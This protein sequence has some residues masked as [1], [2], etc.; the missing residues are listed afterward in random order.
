MTIMRA[1]VRSLRKLWDENVN[2]YHGIAPDLPETLFGEFPFFRC[3]KRCVREHFPPSIFGV[4]KE[5]EV[6]LPI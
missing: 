4:E 1:L 2:P 6:Y 5:R 3:R